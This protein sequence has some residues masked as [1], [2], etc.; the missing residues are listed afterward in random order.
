M[1]SACDTQDQLGGVGVLEPRATLGLVAHESADRFRRGVP[2][3]DRDAGGRV[4]PIRDAT[5]SG[6]TDVPAREHEGNLSADGQPQAVDQYPVLADIEHPMAARGGSRR[7]VA[8][9]R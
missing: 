6:T 4:G 2:V 8:Y 9:D 7:S 5:K 1:S 3:I